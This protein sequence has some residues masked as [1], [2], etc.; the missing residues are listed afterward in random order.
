MK[1]IILSLCT[2]LLLA[3]CFMSFT[4]FAESGKKS[5]VYADKVNDGTYS[6]EVT[7]SSSMFKIVDCQLTVAD[8]EMTAVMTL[9]GT[10]YEKLFMGTGEEA[11]SAPDDSC[12]Y[13]AE[14]PE[15]KYTYTVPVEA[16]DKD[17]DCAAWSIKKQ[18]WYDRTIVFESETLPDGAIKGGVNT[19]LIIGIAAAVVVV[20]VAVVIVRM[21][22]KKTA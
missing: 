9:S 21:K 12:I 11:E 15:G 7:S 6:I 16:L 2:V 14:N 20:I 19:V 8:G 1:K 5:P 17:I 3:F 22:K 18:K 4:V 10:G 13:F